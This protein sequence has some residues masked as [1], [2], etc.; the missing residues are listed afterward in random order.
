MMTL[1]SPQAALL[2]W[3]PV[4]IAFSSGVLAFVLLLLAVQLL[5]RAT[6]FRH[7]ARYFSKSFEDAR[8]RPDA[9]LLT[10]FSAFGLV[11]VIVAVGEFGPSHYWPPAY[12]WISLVGFVASGYG[13]SAFENRAKIQAEGAVAQAQATGQPAPGPITTTMESTTTKATISE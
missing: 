9:K 5:L 2:A 4:L 3:A 11:I 10:L 8:D 1:P 7:L 12:I 6:S 13:F